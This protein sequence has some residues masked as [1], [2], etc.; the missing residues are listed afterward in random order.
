MSFSSNCFRVLST[1]LVSTFL[2]AASASAAVLASQSPLD[3][4]DGF[5]SS[6][7]FGLQ[8]GDTF[9]V[10]N[11]ATVDALTWWGTEVADT[12]G[13]NV[14]LFDSLAPGA[15]PLFECGI[16][17]SSAC[18]LIASSGPVASN[19]DQLG[20]FEYT[21][22]SLSIPVTGGGTFLF[23]VG[24]ELESLGWFW[25]TSADGDDL[26]NFRGDDS[27]PWDTGAPDLAFAVQGTVSTPPAD[28]PEPGS[29]ALLGLAATA[30][31]LTR[32]RI[33]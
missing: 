15:T 19:A 30:L 14:R 33:S 1:T 12:T 4:G 2:L 17:L 6:L 29:M 9:T 28:V 11:D 31:L 24:H 21:L 22:D 10:A 23:S 25:A 20:I 26:S 27:E 32:H 13:F 16:S 8:N 18:G 5:D 7:D 3:G